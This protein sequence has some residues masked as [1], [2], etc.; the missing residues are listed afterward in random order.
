MEIHECLPG[1]ELVSYI[2][3]I[4]MVKCYTA[5]KKGIRGCIGWIERFS[6]PL[7]SGKKEMQKTGYSS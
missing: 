5:D 4:Q 2:T 3:Y 1:E 6:E 7:L